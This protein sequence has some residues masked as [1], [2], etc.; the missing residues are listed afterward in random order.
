MPI[1]K[2]VQGQLQDGIS[3]ADPRLDGGVSRLGPLVAS[4]AARAPIGYLGEANA[5]SCC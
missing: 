1:A 3:G 2:G 4:S 5:V